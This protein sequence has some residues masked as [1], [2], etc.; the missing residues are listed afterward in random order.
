MLDKTLTV[1]ERERRIEQAL[2]EVF[3]LELWEIHDCNNGEGI[4][5]AIVACLPFDETGVWPGD[6]IEFSIPVSLLA[7]ELEKA[8]S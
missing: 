2:E 6:W 5:R 1:A 7:R 3:P 8:L 4:Y